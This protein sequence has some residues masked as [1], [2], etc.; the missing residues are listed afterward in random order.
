MWGQ[1]PRGLDRRAVLCYLEGLEGEDTHV[2]VR[3]RF[4]PSPTGQVHIGNIRVAIF[5]WLFARH[6][7][8]RFLLRVED[9][10]RERSTPEAVQAVLDVMAWLGLDY[11]E[12]PVY[13]SA[14]AEAHGAAAEHLLSCGAAYREDRGGKGECVVFRMPGADVVFRDE[15]K[16]DL[17]KQAEDLQD[18][19]IVRSNG[20]PV[21][22]LANVVDDIAMN[23][24][25]VIRGDDH[26]ENTYRHVVLFRALGA[27][28]PKY[29]HLPMIVNQHGKPY[30]KRDGD[31]Y[32]GDF[33][34]RGFNPDA[35][36]NYLSLLGW[37]PGEDREKMTRNEA[38]ELFTLDRVKSSAAQFDLRKLM[39]LNA[40]YVA[41]LPP[42]VF[43]ARVREALSGVAWAQNVDRDYFRRVAGLMQTRTHLF[44][45]A[46][47]WSY[48]FR[49]DIDYDAKA[50]RKY[51]QK[52]GRPEALASLRTLLAECEFT[53]E[54]V[55]RA[56][57]QAEAGAGLGE[58]KLN[59]AVRVAVTGTAVGAG[60]Y[61]TIA[62]LGRERVLRRLAYAVAEFNE[63][64]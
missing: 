44:L 62:L 50:V 57:R 23:V 2:S 59:Q 1:W 30:S 56:L 34:A 51:V 61:E 29:A 19:V 18:F 64:V 52:E 11:D 38:I 22:H 43:I 33:R 8:G 25:H 47:G 54:A 37:S 45:Y 41:E 63:V 21:F 35:L 55:E 49:D 58:G 39:H 46:E 27:E 26:I 60:V 53:V 7:G 15:I 32:V 9:T 16:G 17:R 13:Q 24:S 40:E 5:N 36:F 6:S 4:A 20:T 12:E 3:V 28:P 48:F 42:D 14:R 10:D 31:A